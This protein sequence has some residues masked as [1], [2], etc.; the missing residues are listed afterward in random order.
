ML[1]TCFRLCVDPRTFAYIAHQAMSTVGGQDGFNCKS[2]GTLIMDLES[3][4]LA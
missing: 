2:L 4:A 3:S 1:L